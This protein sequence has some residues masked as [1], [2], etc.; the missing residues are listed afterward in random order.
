MLFHDNNSR[1]VR[2]SSKDR[3]QTSNSR[4]DIVYDTNDYDLQLIKKV[5]LKS[6]IIPNT[7]YNVNTYNNVFKFDYNGGDQQFT[8]PV[9]QY[10]INDIIGELTTQIDAIITPQTV[11]IVQTA[12]TQKLTF[13]L[14]AGTLILYNEDDGNLLGGVLGINETSSAPAISQTADSLTSLEG[15]KNVYIASKTLSNHTAMI[16]R[17]KSKQNIFCNIPITATFGSISTVEEDE[18]TLDYTNF[19]NKKNISSI[20]IKLL[21]ENNNV[22]DLNGSDWILIFRVYH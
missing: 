6:A 9:G 2:I 16:T 10:D 8:V 4:Y 17:N 5:V 1:L 21:D 18:S 19:H 22:L 15:L 20:D 12:L 14:S 11:S 3:S 13:T 7:M